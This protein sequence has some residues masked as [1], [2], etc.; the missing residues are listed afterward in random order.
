MARCKI[1]PI[2]TAVFC[3]ASVSGG[4]DAFDTESLEKAKTINGLKQCANTLSPNLRANTQLRH[5]VSVIRCWHLT[6]R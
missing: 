4:P 2:F 6:A 5:H 3:S 1:V